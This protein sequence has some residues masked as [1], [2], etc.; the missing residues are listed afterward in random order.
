MNFAV[1]LSLLTKNFQKGIKQVQNSIRGLRAQFQG[2]MS[3][4]GLGFGIKELVDN[5]KNLDK[6]RAVLRNVSSSQEVYGENLEFVMGL[7]KKYN[8]ELI[9]LMSNYAKFHSAAANANFT[10]EEQKFI[11]EALTR[12]ASFFNLTADETNGVM[13]A[14]EQMVSKGKV[15]TE[16]LRRQLGERLPGAMNLAAK[17]MGNITVGQLDEMIRAGKLMAKDLLPMLASELYALTSNLN[18]DHVQGAIARLKNSFTELVDKLGV[19]NIYKKFLNGLSSGINKVTSDTQKA[20]SALISVV[21]GLFLGSGASKGFKSWVE[22][23]EKLENR[24]KRTT[25]AA[26]VARAELKSF[27]DAH[28]V[29]VGFDMQGK[30]HARQR[31]SF[32][33][34]PDKQQ[35][36]NKLIKEYNSLIGE[37]GKIQ[38]ELDNRTKNWAKSLGKAALNALK[39]VGINLLFNAITIAITAAITATVNWFRKLNEVKRAIKNIKKELDQNL[40][41]ASPDQ[42][43][44]ES[45]VLTEDDKQIPE[46]R[47][48]KIEEINRLLGRTG[49]LAFTELS[50][51]ED[52]NAALQQRINHLKKIN[53]LQ[54][55][56]QAL[57]DLQK[58]WNEKAG[59]DTTI[60][61]IKQQL[62]NKN[63]QYTQTINQPSYGGAMYGGNTNLQMAEPIA[64]D[65]KKL[66]QLVTLYEEIEKL[67]KEIA[68]ITITDDYRLTG[69]GNS[70]NGDIGKAAADAE[71]Y[72]KVQAE[73]NNA[74]RA[75]KEK[76]ADGIIKQHEYNKALKDLTLSTLDNIYAIETIDENTDEFAKKIRSAARSFIA[77][78]AQEEYE[79]IQREYN[80]KVRALDDR[81]SDGIITQKDYNESLADLNTSTLNS[82]YALD[83]INE[84]A[85]EFAKKLKDQVKTYEKQKEVNEALDNYKE[86]VQK[87]RRQYIAG[88][89]TKKELDDGLYDLLQEVVLTISGLGQLDAAA[90]ELADKFKKQKSSK[91][92]EELGKEEK[93]E[94]GE[95]SGFF[96]YK[97]TNSEML[98]EDADFLEDYAKNLEQYIK[99]LEEYKDELTGDDLKN[100]IQQIGEMEGNLATLQSQ[101]E[102]FAQAAKFAEVQEDI[103]NMKKELRA[104]IWENITGI[105]TAAERLTNS[106]KSLREIW[107]DPEVDGWEKFINIFTTIMSIIETCVSVI[108][109]FQAAM[110][111][112]EGLSLATAA[113]EQAGIPV[114]M[115]ELALTKAQ[116]VAAKEVATAK[117]LAAAASV[118]YP[119]NL[120]AIASTSAALAAAFAA[121]PAF[122][123]GGVVPGNSQ[124][125]D[126]ILARLNS[127]ELVLNKGQQ[128]ALWEALNTKNQG[129]NVSFEIRGDKLV[130]VLNNY[131]RKIH[132]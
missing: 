123:T 14:I 17:A 93:P 8:Q 7:S 70:G 116:A 89:I 38:G 62:A 55:K 106:F 60:D 126:K 54:S 6:A 47:K 37:T 48:K 23:G 83:D 42:V 52:I 90:R 104:G 56:Q 125:G 118:P 61:D 97:Q 20:F 29:S 50:T 63:T 31:I 44:A 59:K 33:G 57:A 4:I 67:K 112:A 69:D 2:L 43:L 129:G 19:G 11:F 32:P 98:K 73:Y 64:R 76:L 130:G 22:F 66:E 91:V 74:Y 35:K 81:L 105:A 110:A 117:H 36:L 58:V 87:L 99:T 12:A 121:I 95:H 26:K 94:I 132:K 13:L 45:L 78:E 9:T 15:S 39:M 41:D 96:S 82:I 103:K 51:D 10:L 102:T 72:D 27:T 100:L 79:K 107:N 65:I 75:L 124:H 28:N 24:L 84:N 113:A 86:S 1:S 68:D 101:A 92:L 21:G 3:G 77:G 119:A 88:V 131:N 80:D 5:A 46:K 128:G 16:E 49:K 114:K 40:L 71:A 111:V 122:A 30:A 34:D 115:E 120:A 108:K 109:T 25:A 53:E 127:G 85:A 18:V